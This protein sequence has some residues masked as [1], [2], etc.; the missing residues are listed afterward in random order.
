[1][2]KPHLLYAT[3]SYL[4]IDTFR[5]GCEGDLVVLQFGMFQRL[6][7]IDRFCLAQA[8]NREKDISS[9]KLGL[10]PIKPGLNRSCLFAWIGDHCQSARAPWSRRSG[11]NGRPAVYETAAL[12]TELRRPSCEHDNLHGFYLSLKGF[13]AQHSGLPHQLPRH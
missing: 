11:L 1:M 9:N 8:T 3:S 7:K 10:P 6:K 2:K 12:P 4:W 5:W 13:F